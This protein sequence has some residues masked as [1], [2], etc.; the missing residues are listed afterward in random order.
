MNWKEKK[1]ICEGGQWKHS[2]FVLQQFTF[3]FWTIRAA[4][5]MHMLLFHSW[6]LF[7]Y[8]Y[9]IKISTPRPCKKFQQ[10]NLWSFERFMDCICKWLVLLFD[11]ALDGDKACLSDKMDEIWTR[12]PP[13]HCESFDVTIGQN[14]YNH[15]LS[16]MGILPKWRC[17]CYS[18]EICW[19]CHNFHTRLCIVRIAPSSHMQM[20][21]S[22]ASQS[23][24]RYFPKNYYVWM[25]SG[26]E[27][28]MNIF[29]WKS[30]PARIGSAANSRRAEGNKRDGWWLLMWGSM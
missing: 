14:D 17:W 5:S 19:K 8:A 24:C 3:D 16:T 21:L 26:N 27:M 13:R 18:F 1:S 11:C 9:P 7:E 12:F 6:F 2:P 20:N 29:S 22:P 30:K 4:I 23:V 25:V 10:W 28:A 15:R